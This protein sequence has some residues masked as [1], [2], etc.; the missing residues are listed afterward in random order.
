MKTFYHLLANTQIASVINYT[1]WFA[2]TF[3]V[4]LQTRSVFAT[5]MISGIYL[6][7]TTVSG[8]WFGSLVDRHKKKDVMLLSSACH[9]FFISFLS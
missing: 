2:I 3:F 7:L 4:F 5:G 6:V 9:Y 8:F 1:A